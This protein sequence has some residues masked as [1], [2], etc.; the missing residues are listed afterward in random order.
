MR[1]NPKPTPISTSVIH[2][3]QFWLFTLFL[4]LALPLQ[5]ADNTLKGS[6]PSPKEFLANSS[7]PLPAAF[8]AGTLRAQILPKNYTT[9]ANELPARIDKIHVPEGGRFQAGEL[10]VTL[11]C[12][13]QKAQLTKAI[14]TLNSAERISSVHAK[15]AQMKTMG[16]LEAITSAAE[17]E[18]ARADL[19]LMRATVAKCT[20]TAPFAGRVAEQKVREHQ[21][22]QAGQPLLDILDDSQLIIEFIVPSRWLTWLKPE[23]PFILHVDETDK[24]YPAKV[25]RI[26]ARVDA[27]NQS[28][29]VNGAFIDPTP[30]LLAGMSGRAEL[31]PPP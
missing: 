6:L 16:K 19:T 8:Q 7:A 23:I 26:G 14:A 13:I 1:K 22:L 30:E 27:V 29:K 15:L 5:A 17:A 28:I 18:K 3:N 31:N 12:A 20:L 10:L 11:D 25:T 21:Y 2:A 9:L 24:N 4:L